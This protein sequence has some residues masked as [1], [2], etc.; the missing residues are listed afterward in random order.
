MADNGFPYWRWFPKDWRGD[1]DLLQVSMG[2]RGLF[3]YIM[4][5][6]YESPVP[7]YLYKAC[8]KPMTLADIKKFYPDTIYK[9][10]KFFDEL[11][12][13]NLVK[14]SEEKEAYFCPKIV[15]FLADREG[16][17]KRKSKERNK[18]KVGKGG[19][20]HA[21]SHGEC[22][23]PSHA[24]CHGESHALTRD[25]DLRGSDLN[26]HVSTAYAGLNPEGRARGGEGAP[27][28]PIPPPDAPSPSQQANQQ[29]DQQPTRQEDQHTRRP[30]TAEEERQLAKLIKTKA[31]EIEDL[32]CERSDEWRAARDAES[33]KYLNGAIK[34]VEEAY[35]CHDDLEWAK[36]ALEKLFEL[37][38]AGNDPGALD[39]AFK[40]CTRPYWIARS[41][42]SDDWCL[43]WAMARWTPGEA[44]EDAE[45]VTP[46]SAG[47]LHGRAKIAALDVLTMVAQGRAHEI[48]PETLAE[49]PPE[50][51]EEF[52]TY[53]AQAQTYHPQPAEAA[54]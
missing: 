45:G 8:G 51:R 35:R 25:R 37:A 11:L 48:P 29:P 39:L 30:G 10:S 27:G 26:Q 5:D 22:H 49:I 28:A 21:P 23:A 1:L 2:A 32:V 9:V 33:P 52:E 34:A 40:I 46:P 24:P 16:S 53:I 44:P 17:K 6:A 3:V 31:L 43:E 15:K 54:T 13:Q 18:K 42:T 36:I 50:R 12:A 19:E 4:G 41:R 47:G 7:G 20:C 38:D 14:Y